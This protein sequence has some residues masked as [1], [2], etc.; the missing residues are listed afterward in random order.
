MNAFLA[1]EEPFEAGPTALLVVVLLGIGI[2]ILTRS[3]LKHLRR[4]PASFDPPE[5]AG[6]IEETEV[7][8]PSRGTA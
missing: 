7:D 8:P 5:S 4:V 3:M 1:A 6:P 2:V